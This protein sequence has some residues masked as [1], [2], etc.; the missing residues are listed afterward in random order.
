MRKRQTAVYVITNTGQ[1]VVKVGIS[2]D[3][4]RRLDTLQTGCPN[5]LSLFYVAFH[6]EAQR[7]ET[8]VHHALRSKRVHGEWFQ[9]SADAAKSEIGR[10]A[11]S[12]GKPIAGSGW[13]V[14]RRMKH[15][16]FFLALWIIVLTA[17]FAFLFSLGT[18]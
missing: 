1:G 3:P 13:L 10:A 12:I 4:T 16:W 18:Q 17:F 8:L 5:E 2:D 9:V 11:A 14:G 7:I 6:S 15:F